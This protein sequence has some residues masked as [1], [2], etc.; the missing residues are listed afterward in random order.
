M[1]SSHEASLVGVMAGAV[2]RLP[3][4]VTLDVDEA[5]QRQK[6]HLPTGT[7]RGTRRVGRLVAITA[8]GAGL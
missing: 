6:P 1:L 8:R 7:G 3:A 2:A 4:N 5:Q